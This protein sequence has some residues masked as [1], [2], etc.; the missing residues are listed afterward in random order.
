VAEKLAAM[1]DEVNGFGKLLVFGFDYAEQ[2][3]VWQRSM[4]LLATEVGPKVA[5]LRPVPA[6]V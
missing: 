2:P 3:E 6:T 1:Y 5:S 4:Q